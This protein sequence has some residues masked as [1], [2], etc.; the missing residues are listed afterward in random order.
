[1]VRARVASGA[2]GGVPAAPAGV[3]APALSAAT[4]LISTPDRDQISITANGSAGA[5]SEPPAAGGA[6]VAEPV[7][8]P[9]ATAAGG[10][11]GVPPAAPPRVPS[12]AAAPL[13]GQ[14]PRRAPAAPPRR[15][16]QPAPP[17]SNYRSGRVSRGFIAGLGV[18]GVVLVVVVLLIVTSNGGSSAPRTTASSAS[19]TTASKTA[20][21]SKSAAAAALKA[22]S[23]TVAV[24]NGTSTNNL[25]KTI[26]NRLGAVGYKPG[27]I[28]NASDQTETATVVGYLPHE[29]R[30]GLLVAKSLSLGPAS[31]QPVDQS[32]L[33]VACPTSSTPCTAQV[34]VTV[35]SDLA[36]TT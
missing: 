8:P 10:A 17:R 15:V 27:N 4:K 32:N 36:S 19:R 2:S 28:T 22:S 14:L 18:L 13:P 34:V 24:L 35:G 7:G 26:S 31:V 33:T 5:V 16:A 12:P 11:N 6:T 20:R 23:I 21:R 25:A 3:G 1:V 9:P 30:A 29:R